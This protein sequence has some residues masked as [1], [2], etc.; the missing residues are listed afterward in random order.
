M[1]STGIVFQQLRSGRPPTGGYMNV[2]DL[3]A[4]LISGGIT[5]TKM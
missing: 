3:D 5:A 4:A 1:P 2:F